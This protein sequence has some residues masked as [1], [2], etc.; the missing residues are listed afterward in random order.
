MP[1]SNVINTPTLCELL[2]P[3]ITKELIMTTISS[4]LLLSISTHFDNIFI[5]FMIVIIDESD[6]YIPA[7]LATWTLGKA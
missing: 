4:L 1:G 6:Q 2:T 3:V 5:Q 7:G